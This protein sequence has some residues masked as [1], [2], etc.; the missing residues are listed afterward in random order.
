M[1]I[2]ALPDYYTV[3]CLSQQGFTPNMTGDTNL[4]ACTALSSEVSRIKTNQQDFEDVKTTEVVS[5]FCTSN[6][7]RT[8]QIAPV[9]DRRASTGRFPRIPYYK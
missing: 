7:P 2:G 5:I 3:R 9:L 1:E 8:R 6:T 4:R